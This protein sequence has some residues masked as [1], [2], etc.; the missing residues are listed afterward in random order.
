[1]NPNQLGICRK[2]QIW[3]TLADVIP[4]ARIFFLGPVRP[5]VLS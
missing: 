2:R 5:R 1:M 4:Y 3:R